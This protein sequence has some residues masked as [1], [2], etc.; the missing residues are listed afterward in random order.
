[1]VRK[2]NIISIGSVALIIIWLWNEISNIPK[3]LEP[4]GTIAVGM[5]IDNV[6][7]ISMVPESP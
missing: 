2:F 3:A 4:A 5:L 6:R 7:V 1:M